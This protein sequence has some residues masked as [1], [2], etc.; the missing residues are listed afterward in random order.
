MGVGFTGGGV[1]TGGVEVGLRP[2]RMSVIDGFG[3]STGVSTGGVAT[4]ATGVLTG[5]S[6]ALGVPLTRATRL[7]R[8]DWI[9]VRIDF[10][11][12]VF[13]NYLCFNGFR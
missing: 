7:N 5:A 11:F 2:N 12:I 1:D 10:R 4:G 13:L 8:N 6:G 9:V 3:A